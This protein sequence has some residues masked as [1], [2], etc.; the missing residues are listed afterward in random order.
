MT[1][2]TIKR[3]N[4]VFA[5]VDEW[6]RL[7]FKHEQRGGYFCTVNRLWEHGDTKEIV[8]QFL[9]HADELYVKC[10]FKDFEGE[11][12]HPVDLID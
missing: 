10:P 7:V 4:L 3:S 2:Q 12:Y 5:G 8:Q 11:P 1:Q 6:C 9:D